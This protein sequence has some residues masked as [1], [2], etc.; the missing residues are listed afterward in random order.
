MSAKGFKDCSMIAFDLD[1]TL[2]DSAAFAV[3]AVLSALAELYASL[4]VTRALPTYEQVRAQIGQPFAQFYTGLLPHELEG[5]ASSLHEAI[6]EREVEAMR[7]GRAKLFA[8]AETVLDELRRR[9]YRLAL[10]SNASAGYFRAA[11]DTFGLTHWFSH[12]ECLGD[13]NRPKPT[14]FRSA[15]DQLGSAVGAMVGDKRGD[16]AAAREHGMPAIGVAYGYGTADELAEATCTIQGLD[17][18]LS[19]FPRASHV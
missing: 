9:G 17:E 4:E 8:H 18:L 1:G 13:A 7:T 10:I 5:H 15:L 16:I 19:L 3:D 2:L 11:I 6:F 14:M 12:A